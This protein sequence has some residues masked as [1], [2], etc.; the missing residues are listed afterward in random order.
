M[1]GEIISTDR[2]GVRDQVVERIRKEATTTFYL[3]AAT[4]LEWETR[5]QTNLLKGVP[6]EDPIKMKVL[7]GKTREGKEFTQVEL[8]LKPQDGPFRQ[9]WMVNWTYLLELPLE[10]GT[11]GVL[12]L[13]D[14]RAI[15]E[16]ETRFLGLLDTGDLRGVQNWRRMEQTDIRTLHSFLQV[17]RTH[18]TPYK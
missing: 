13:L 16:N 4:F 17:A 3:P 1:A 5:P 12:S 9:R 7:V 2:K 8:N 18:F 14:E 6:P 15:P 10:G 11:P